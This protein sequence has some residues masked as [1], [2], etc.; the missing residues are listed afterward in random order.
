MYFFITVYKATLKFHIGFSKEV[1]HLNMHT[2]ASEV[3]IP[4]IGGE[5]LL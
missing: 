4:I 1:P 3:G 2:R 5:G